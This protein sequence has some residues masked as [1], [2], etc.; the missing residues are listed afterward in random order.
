MKRKH[1][2]Y[3]FVAALFCF[4]TRQALAQG[5]ASCYTSA[6]A[7]GP[8]TAHALRIG[9]L[10]LLIPP[11][12]GF[13]GIL[14]VLRHWRAWDTR[15]NSHLTARPSTRICDPSQTGPDYAAWPQAEMASNSDE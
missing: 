4:A 2:I 7:G 11:I 1:A 8:Q 3:R 15:E 13:T 12:L 6:A 14:F 9:I 10:L 5:C